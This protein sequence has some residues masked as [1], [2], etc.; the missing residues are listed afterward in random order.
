VSAPNLEIDENGYY[1]LEWLDGY[2]QT[3]STLDA[4]IGVEMGIYKVM[5]TSD[6]GI[7]W[8]GEFVSSV[9]PASYTDNGMAH[10]VLA[11]WEEMIGDTLSVWAGYHD[12][13][14]REHIDSIGVIVEDEI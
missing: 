10:T 9:N 6:L 8:G 2:N 13:C 3:F 11:V 14:G 5:W 12:E 7:M 1:H 4:N